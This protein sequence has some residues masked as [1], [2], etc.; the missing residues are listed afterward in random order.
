M[1]IFRNWIFAWWQVSII[2]IC[3]ISLGI[4]LGIYFYDYL[5]GLLWLWW[6][7][8]ITTAAYFIIELM[9]EN[10]E[11]WDGKK[12]RMISLIKQ[13]GEVANNDIENL[14]GV[15]DSTATRYLD[16]LEK[17]GIVFQVGETGKAVRYRLK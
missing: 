5:A 14:L 11:G 4:L 16:R 13:M 2:K 17:E 7:L 12:G 1:K 3:L 6:L 9:R 10:G 8:F 15:S